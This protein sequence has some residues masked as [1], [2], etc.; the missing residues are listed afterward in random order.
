M[1][2]LLHSSEKVGCGADVRLDSGE[3]CLVSVAQSG[4]I[5]RAGASRLAKPSPLKNSS[6][7]SCLACARRR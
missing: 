6:G 7:S 4:V 3:L 2:E 5:V 1:P